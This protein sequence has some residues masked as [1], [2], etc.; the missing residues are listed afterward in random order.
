M[1]VP[2]YITDP[3]NGLAAR[4]TEFGQLVTSPIAYSVPVA[5]TLS[6][7]DTAYN[8]IEPEANHQIVITDI[9]LTSDKNVGA[10]GASVQVYCADAVDSTTVLTDGGVLDIEMLKNT[11]RDLI[12]LNFIVGKGFWVNAKT[13]DNN[14]QL[15]IGYYR[16]PVD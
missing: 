4:V 8:Y 16:V 5:Q 6:V 12:G 14:I 15:T 1:P 11:S 7:I 9:I 3:H 2:S 10:S 13:D